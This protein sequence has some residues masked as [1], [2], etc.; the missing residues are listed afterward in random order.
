MTVNVQILSL[1][2]TPL[3]NPGYGPE[4]CWKVGVK[5][6]QGMKR[7]QS[8]KRTTIHLG[9]LPETIFERHENLLLR[10]KKNNRS[11]K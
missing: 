4:V 5:H 8:T 11:S 9:S 3:N 2:N 10:I 6:L 1:S 7:H